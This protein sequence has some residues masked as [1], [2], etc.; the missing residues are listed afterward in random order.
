M[1]DGL[2]NFPNTELV[3]FNRWGKKIYESKNYQNDWN[4]DDAADGVYYWILN[5]ADG[6]GTNMKGTLTI[7]SK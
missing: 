6:L 2:A 5:L 3:V 1:I 4:G 7:I